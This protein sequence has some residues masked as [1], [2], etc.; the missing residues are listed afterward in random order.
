MFCIGWGLCSGL[1][2]GCLNVLFILYFEVVNGFLYGK[3]ICI[4][5]MSLGAWNEEIIVDLVVFML[6]NVRVCKWVLGSGRVDS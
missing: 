1:K 2:S 5:I 3:E 6:N 4:D